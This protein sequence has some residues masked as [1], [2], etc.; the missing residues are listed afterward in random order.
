LYLE[1]PLQRIVCLLHTNE[2]PLRHLFRKLDGETSGPTTFK[3]P[4]GRLLDK[5]DQSPVRNDFELF[6]NELFPT[7]DEDGR[8]DL[9][10]DQMYLLN[11]CN[12]IRG[13]PDGNLQLASQHK[14]GKLC[15]SRW[16]TTGSRLLRLYI[17]TS[18]SEPYYNN[19]FTI[20]K[21]IILV[22]GP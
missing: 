14:I 6:P 1:R 22:Y 11:I 18:K 17:S 8:K 10:R 5:C 21:F 7:L 4:I 3:G 2:L 15:H 19:L 9:S 13:S 12:V 16:L 20:V